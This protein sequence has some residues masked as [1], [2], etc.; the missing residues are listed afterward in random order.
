MTFFSNL[1]CLI[2]KI[3]PTHACCIYASLRTPGVLD[4]IG[5]W[6]WNG[7]VVCSTSACLPKKKIV[8]KSV[9]AFGHFSAEMYKGFFFYS[10][11][12][13]GKHGGVVGGGRQKGMYG[14]LNYL[15]WAR[16]KPRLWAGLKRLSG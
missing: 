1:S 16:K 3:P 12:L 9:L 15:E 6:D 10:A 4:E 13:H 11:E 8:I 14:I 7:G 5:D 2:V